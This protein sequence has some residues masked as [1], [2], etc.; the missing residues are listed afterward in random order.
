[1]WLDLSR[2]GY[3][4][5]GNAGQSPLEAQLS[6]LCAWVLLADKQGT[7]YGLRLGALEIGPDLGEAHK[8]A[9]LQALARY[10]EAA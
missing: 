6:R 10:G 3:A 7:R 1:L 9:C 8:R 5:G 2:T 4:A